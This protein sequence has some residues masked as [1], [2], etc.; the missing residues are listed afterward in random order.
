MDIFSLSSLPHEVLEVV[1]SQLPLFSLLCTC[2]RVCRQWHSIIARGK[3]LQWRKLY[4][5]YKLDMEYDQDQEEDTLPLV[6]E[7]DHPSV[8]LSSYQPTTTIDTSADSPLDHLSWLLHFTSHK[9]HTKS[10]LFS[11]ITRHPRYDEAKT[12]LSMTWSDLSSSLPSVT[13]WLLLTSPSVWSVRRVARELVSSSSKAT[14][15][16]ITEYLYM[17]AT[18]L[19]L[20][21][22]T[23]TLPTRLHYLV[24]HAL[25]YLENDWAVT[26]VSNNNT[27]Q[28]PKSQGQQ[29][30]M[31]M[32][33]TKSV[34][35]KVPTA[36]QLR[37]IQHPL[38]KDRKDLVKIVAFAG[39]G[40]TTTLVR[41]AEAHPNL[42]FLLVVYNKSVRLQAEQQFPK[43]H[44]VCKTVHQMAMAKC[45][46]MFSKKMTSNLKA[47][48]ILDSGL[49][50]EKGEEDSSVYRRAGQVLATLS[51]FMNSPD[52]ELELEHVPSTWSIDSRSG[53]SMVSLT[54]SQRRVVLGDTEVVWRAMSDKD[55]MKIRMPH[56]GY[57]KLWQLRSPSLQRVTQH[58][59]LLLDE[60]Q[61][62]N[63]AMLSIFMNQSVTRVIVGDPHQQIYM[64]R[65]AV[66]ALDLVDPT[67]TYF[68]TQSFRFGPEIAFVANKCLVGLKGRDERTLVGGRKVDSFLGTNLDQKKQVAFIGRTNIGLFDKLNKLIFD[69]DNKKRVGLVGGLDGYNFEDYLDIYH[70][71]VGEMKKMKK[72]KAWKSYAQFK[73]FA[74]NVNDVELLS[75]IKI[76]EK[77]G[78]RLPAIIDK[79]KSVCCKDIRMADIVLSTVHK[80]KGLEFETVVLLNDFPDFNDFG[81]LQMV[82]EDE[83]NLI[84]VAITRAKTS[85]VMNTLVKEDILDGDGL[86]RVVV[87][88]GGCTELQCGNMDCKVDLSDS[89]VEGQVTVRTMAHS[90]SSGVYFGGVGLG[91]LNSELVRDR[92]TYCQTCAGTRVPSYKRFLELESGKRGMKRKRE[93]VTV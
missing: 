2:S 25:Y 16:E 38:S 13:T 86:D 53:Q 66:N 63:P 4:Y 1:F 45:G 80:A 85:L 24:F 93:G 52:M 46:F 3:F 36:E 74:K 48:D 32:G 58:D 59:V 37:I 23:T 71:M 77:F 69:G 29:S 73:A 5:R 75:K 41:L 11:T 22:R 68:L 10:H 6:L 67:H 56:D 89:L 34:P 14:T 62:M 31:S 90:L 92:Q 49:L 55:D 43:A 60:G 33:F 87:Y 7:L 54:A 72:Y 39:T 44:V 26:P 20:F 47:K 15:G 8:I 79:I 19:L 83:K 51:T 61:D 17:V 82:P 70:L 65:G 28:K 81:T 76:I 27:V 78:A 21:Q 57:L 91:G 30:L 42:R 88:K 40:K 50:V 84:Y 18:F 9:F 64:F 35:S 12:S